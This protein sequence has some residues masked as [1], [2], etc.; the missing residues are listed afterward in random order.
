MFISGRRTNIVYIKKVDLK[1]VDSAV[2]L[3]KTPFGMIGVRMAKT[4]GINDGG[5]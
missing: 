5:G 2:M 4:I 3:G 1:A